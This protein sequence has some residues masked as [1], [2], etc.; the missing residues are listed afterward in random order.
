MVRPFCFLPEVHRLALSIHHRLPPSV[1]PSPPQPSPLCVI[2]GKAGVVQR[3]CSTLRRPEELMLL[4][5]LLLRSD[6]RSNTGKNGEQLWRSEKMAW[7]RWS[8]RRSLSPLGSLPRAWFQVDVFFPVKWMDVGN[9]PPFYC[10][11][12]FLCFK[13]HF[14]QPFQRNGFLWNSF[15]PD[16][17]LL[18]SMCWYSMSHPCWTS[19][20]GI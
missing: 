16:G 17:A 18:L 4:A 6:P 11:W 14:G 3:K 13:Q 20:S 8:K 12:S 19:S 5:A 1:C 7:R 2:S 15:D 10:W 9:F